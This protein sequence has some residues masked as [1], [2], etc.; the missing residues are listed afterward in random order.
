MNG[1]EQENLK[2]LARIKDEL[3]S[4]GR[5]HLKRDTIIKRYDHLMDKWNR[6]LALAKKRRER[7][8][9]I[10]NQFQDIEDKF[11]SF[12]KKASAFNSWFENAEEDLTD[13]VKI[14]FVSN[15]D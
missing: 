11:L 4:P 6:L 7:L 12:A 1:F 10:Q 8:M 9:E 5:N 13:P 2:A 14:S 15:E 3:A